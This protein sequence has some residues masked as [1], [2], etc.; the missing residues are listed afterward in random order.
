MRIVADVNIIVSATIGPLGTPRAIIAAFDEI[1][2][3]TGDPEDDY[4]LAT[5]HLAG[6][7]YLVTG[8]VKLQ[9]LRSHQ[10]VAIVSP[11]AFFDLITGRR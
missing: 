1:P 6:A 5:A 4:V 9:N 7:D 2:A 11:R 8:D 3:V 10:Q